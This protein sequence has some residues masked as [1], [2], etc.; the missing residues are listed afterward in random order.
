VE[1][2]ERASQSA[3][4]ENGALRAQVSRLQ[5]E[6]REYRKRLTLLGRSGAPAAMPMRALPDANGNYGRRSG[7][8]TGIN[9]LQFDF[10]KFG[11]LPGSH[12]FDN[13]SLVRQ[14]SAS[15]ARASNILVKSSLQNTSPQIGTTG[16]ASSRTEAAN[17]AASSPFGSMGGNFAMTQGGGRF[18]SPDI[19]N[20]S[21][22][23]PSWNDYFQ[24][25]KAD[26]ETGQDQRKSSQ[27]S[28]GQRPYAP[29]SGASMS[30]SA[31]P[32]ASSVSHHAPGSST[33]TTPASYHNSPS[34]GGTLDG[35]MNSISEELASG[36]TTGGGS[37]IC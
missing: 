15:P 11:S 20:S 21:P 17:A 28:V 34:Y 22:P 4:E 7:G 18:G 37:S 26:G 6:L 23:P 10:P 9:D 32:S 12:M 5:E 16:K 24:N 19:V 8:A 14:D 36:E 31:S 25:P 30:S 3:N 2:L 33:A 1:D 29:I 35:P 27:S 13:G